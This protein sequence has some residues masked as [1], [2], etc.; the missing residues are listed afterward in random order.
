MVWARNVTSYYPDEGF[1]IPYHAYRDQPEILE[2]ILVT[3]ENPATCKYGARHLTD[4][5]A[6]GMLEQLLDA[7]GRL[8]EIGDAQEDWDLRQKWVQRSEEGR[9]GKECVDTSRFRGLPY[10]KK[11]KEKK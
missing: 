6:I 9:V 7:I 4:N 1:R 8:K 5:T 10:H 2:K 3:P 11:K